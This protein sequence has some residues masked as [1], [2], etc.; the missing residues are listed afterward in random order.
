MPSF[1]V[2]NFPFALAAKLF[3]M[4][5]LTVNEPNTKSWTM[6]TVAEMISVFDPWL[7]TESGMM[8]FGITRALKTISQ[9]FVRAQRGARASVG[10][11]KPIFTIR[12]VQRDA[13]RMGHAHVSWP[14]EPAAYPLH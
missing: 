8:L 3:P 10:T 9:S 14:R 5:L 2:Q 7:A 13:Y 4:H 1:V 6:Q 12:C 11:N